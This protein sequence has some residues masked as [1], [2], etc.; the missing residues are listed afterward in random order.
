VISTAVDTVSLEKLRIQLTRFEEQLYHIAGK[1]LT[2]CVDVD[3][4]S[5][6]CKG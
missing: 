6:P 3:N 4:L 2:V 5:Q 1:M